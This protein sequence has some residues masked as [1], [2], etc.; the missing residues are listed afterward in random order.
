MMLLRRLYFL[1]PDAATTAAAVH[2][3]SQ[4]GVDQRHMHALARSA[5]EAEHLPLASTAQRRDLSRRLETLLWDGNLGLFFVALALLVIALYQ[6]W[7]LLAVLMAA[8]MVVTFL[9]GLR[10][11]LLPDVHLE[12]FQDALA[13]GEVLLM[14]D[15]PKS[16]VAEVEDHVHRHHPAATVGGV[17]WSVEGMEL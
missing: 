11:T 4:R 15:V 3:L 16:R 9:L 6:D 14:I 1:F 7:A 13:H 17:G 8:A 12:E 5:A 10:A 2:E